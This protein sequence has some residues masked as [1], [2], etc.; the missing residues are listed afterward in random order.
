[1][2][3]NKKIS[4]IV[5]SSLILTLALGLMAFASTNA[6]S[7]ATLTDDGYARRGGPG[8]HRGPDHGSEDAFL[9]E[10]LGIT[11]EELQTAHQAAQSAAVAQALAEG[12]I[13]QAQADR[14]A[15]S[16]FHSFQMFAGPDSDI[17]LDALLADALGISID[18]LSAASETAKATAIEQAIAN[19]KITEEQAALME[20]RQ[21]L[22]NYLEKDE[23]Q[24]KALG[25]SIEELQTALE[26]GQRIPDLLEELGVDQETF[27]TN[28]Q[29]AREEALQQAVEDGVITQTQA[30]LLL[31]N[32]FDDHHGHGGFPGGRE[33][34]EGP[35]DFPVRGNNETDA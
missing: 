11:S 9:A 3:K 10:A 33:G 23:L 13:T 7:A 5:I 12:L 4:L 30:D 18:E 20:A 22:K 31:A 25:I 21:A 2:F 15:E 28:L 27:E 24:A 34:V 17:D 16:G 35:H 19:G 1:M 29:T 26:D 8:G 32:G 6:A 14:I